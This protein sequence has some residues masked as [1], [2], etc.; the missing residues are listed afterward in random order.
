MI[1]L[2]KKFCGTGPRL[3]HPAGAWRDGC[4]KANA[5]AIKV[6]VAKL[7]RIPFSTV[8]RQ[9]QDEKHQLANGKILH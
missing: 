9:R 6:T 5:V 4:F 8:R 3:T 7:G 1:S 2:L